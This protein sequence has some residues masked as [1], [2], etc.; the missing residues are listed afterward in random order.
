MR[1]YSGAF[2]F[3]RT[4]LPVFAALVAASPALLAQAPEDAAPR[5]SFLRRFSIGGRLS[6]LGKALM[7]DADYSTS[8]TS[9]ALSTTIKTISKAQ[10]VGGG[11]TAS[12]EVRPWLSIGAD[13]ICRNTGYERTSS[14]VAGTTTTTTTSE[15]ENT[16]GRYWDVP[17][18][19]R[20]YVREEGV[21]VMRPFI[22]AGG[23]YRRVAK[24]HTLKEFT[25]SNGALDT[26]LTPVAPAHRAL[27]GFVVGAGLQLEDE[28]GFKY[29]PEFRYTR[30]PQRTFDNNPTVSGK[31]QIEFVFG[32]TF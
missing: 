20:V 12:F 3:C 17:V 15:V 30:W 9:P 22:T 31:N 10:R 23:A 8:T 7:N 28:L 25:H 13:L 18:L 2:A 6:V 26:Y 32:F 14:W 27:T 19:A 24:I 5:Q 1:I 16:R 11:A 21:S 29:T 4:V